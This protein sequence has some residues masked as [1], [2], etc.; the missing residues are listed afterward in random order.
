MARGGGKGSHGRMEI[1]NAELRG[2]DTVGHERNGPT[3]S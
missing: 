3:E 2:E 1:K